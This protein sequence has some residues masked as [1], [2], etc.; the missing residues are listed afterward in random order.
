VLFRFIEQVASVP[1]LLNPLVIA[2]YP[3]VAAMESRALV[4][5]WLQRPDG[6]RGVY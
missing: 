1:Q 3:T 6:R 4:D 2:E 5:E